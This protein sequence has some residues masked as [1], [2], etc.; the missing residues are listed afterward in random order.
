MAMG[1]VAVVAPL[2]LVAGHEHGI[3]TLQHQPVK[4]YAME[5][6]FEP[7]PNGAPLILFGMPSREAAETKHA[8]AIPGLGSLVLAGSTDAPLQGLKSFPREDWPPVAIVFWAFRIMVGLGLL[9]IALGAV[10]VLAWATGRLFESRPLHRFA[11]AMGPAG[12]VAVLAG[13]TVTEVGRQPYT[14][15][16][17]LRT[18]DSA[19]PLSA[20]AVGA[21]LMAFVVVYFIVFGAGFL[22]LLRL[23]RRTP[24]APPAET[25]EPMEG[26]IRTAAGGLGSPI[27]VQGA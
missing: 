6:H 13:W 21:S 14:I 25:P 11:L 20:A 18:V 15:Y 22:Y 27:A 1:M 24:G 19:S 17:L 2:Q 9:M 16:G 23:M 10:A 8:I 26:P 3:N 4:V 7:S 5:G 12:F